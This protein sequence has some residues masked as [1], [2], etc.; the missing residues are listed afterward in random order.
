[1]SQ[2]I[3]AIPSPFL[4][5]QSRNTPAV[6]FSPDDKVFE[7]SGISFPED[8]KLFFKP[9]LDYLNEVGS[10]VE[11]GTIFNFKLDYFNT[12]SARCILDVMLAIDRIY[13]AG[14]KITIFWYYSAGDEEMKEVGEEYGLLISCPINLKI[15]A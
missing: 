6:S 8:S 15:I 7:I 2:S 1:M 10:A 11:S 5:K 3:A 4:L 12:S 13:S 9:L 14:A